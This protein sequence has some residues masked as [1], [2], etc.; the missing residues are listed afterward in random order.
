VTVEPAYSGHSGETKT[1]DH[2][3]ASLAEIEAEMKCAAAGE[4][5]E[6]GLRM[7][8]EELPDEGLIRCFAR[9]AEIFTRNAA[10]WEEDPHFP[11]SDGVRF[12]ELGLARDIEIRKVAP[13]AATGP[14]TWLP[15]F[16]E[17]EQLIGVDLRPAVKAIAYEL[18]R[19]PEDLHAAD[20]ADLAS[21]ALDLQEDPGQ[22]SAEQRE[23]GD[24]RGS[25]DDQQADELQGLHP[26]FDVT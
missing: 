19:N 24:D 12:A 21:T 8:P 3:V 23:V 16:R 10:R 2:E 22:A 13:N 18:V 9:D 14:E 17:A 15:I 11:K 4:I 26:G 25:G 6:R 1:V 7:F 20:V 5:A